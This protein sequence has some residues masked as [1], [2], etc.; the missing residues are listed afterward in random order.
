MVYGCPLKELLEYHRHDL[1]LKS[2]CLKCLK[3]RDNK[4][5]SKSEQDHTQ[6]LTKFPIVETRIL[7]PTHKA[8]SAG[9]VL[10]HP[11]K[12]SLGNKVVLAL[13]Y[14]NTPVALLQYSNTLTLL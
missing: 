7:S 2:Y 14:T 11:K 12:D 5:R 6:K 13:P 4:T 3:L 10:A 9:K 1:S 8:V